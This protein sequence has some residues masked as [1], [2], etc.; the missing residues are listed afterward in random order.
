VK[1]KEVHTECMFELFIKYILNEGNHGLILILGNIFVLYSP[2]FT[3]M[4]DTKRRN[5]LT[6]SKRD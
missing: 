6:N 3:N 5:K 2:L 1:A 4:V